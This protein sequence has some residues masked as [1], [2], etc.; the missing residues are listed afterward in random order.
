MELVASDS[1]LDLSRTDQIEPILLS[2]S[3]RRDYW[4]APIASGIGLA[5]A[6]F[7]AAVRS[8]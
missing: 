7:M 6:F 8:V 3:E 4:A 2:L 5:E 1:K